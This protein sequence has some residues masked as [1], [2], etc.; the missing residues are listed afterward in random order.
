MTASRHPRAGRLFPAALVL[1]LA[2]VGPLSARA[3]S[4]APDG[5]GPGGGA[6]RMVA[7]ERAGPGE[8]AGAGDAQRL[9]A[10]VVRAERSLEERFA[11]TGSRVTVTRGDIEQMGA[12]TIAD[13]LQKLP[14]VQAAPNAS[15]SVDIRMRGMDRGATQIL[16]DG[17]RVSGGRAGA[18][19]PFDQ[20]PAD[21]IERIEVLRAPSAEY[22]G[23]TGGTLNIVLRESAPRPETSLRLSG[24]QAF[25]EQAPRLFY[26]RNAGLPGDSRW[27]YLVSVSA[28]ERLWGSDLHREVIGADGTRTGGDDHL[29]GRT[30]E[31]TVLPRLNGR[32]S[33]TDSVVLR[34]TLLAAETDSRS[35]G[36]L[37]GARADG[38]PVAGGSR[39]T[40]DIHRQ[41]MQLRADWTRRLS[42]ARLETRASVERSGERIGRERLEWLDTQTASGATNRSTLASDF[43]DRRAEHAAQ[44]AIKLTGTGSEQV[45]MAGLEYEQRRL[46]IDSH[47]ATGAATPTDRQLSSWFSR[48]V[49]WG[50]NEWAVP[51]RG[52]LT[53]G[54][55]A[56]ALSRGTEVDGTRQ[57]DAPEQW[58]PSLHWR[59][60]LAQGWQARANLARIRKLPALTD[61]IDRVIPGWGSNSPARPDLIGNPALRPET[62]LSLDTGLER[63][64][65]GGGQAG[66]NVFVRSIDDL[67]VRRTTEVAG[68][69]QQRPENLGSAL[70]WGI[71]ADVRQHLGAIGARGWNLS[72]NAS[73]LQSRV[74]DGAGWQG[75]I[76]GQAHYLAN[77]SVARPMPRSGGA[78]GGV[79]LSLKGASDLGTSAA[80]G[81][82]ERAR[83]GVDAHAGQLISGLGFWR[84]DVF[85]L[86]NT[87]IRRE[88]VDAVAAGSR[89]EQSAETWGTRLLI[90]VGT[91]W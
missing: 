20:L 28:G 87:R 2:L 91:R 31:L 13:V 30:R 34:A 66:V 77:L 22:S 46:S 48:R 25:G 43:G 35:E 79:S 6:E 4:G 78:F 62:T 18:Q 55:R 53:A 11:S 12:D 89:Y 76:P 7:G 72:A 57:Q 38:S 68:R 49:L 42:S 69:W 52:T 51:G 21:M 15:G 60:P 47:L 61:T 24:Q 27:T 33:A 58:Q 84:L 39:E 85:N 82:R 73:L 41:L 23:A 88:R 50:Q 75:R 45:W 5:A 17:Q 90:T 70:V 71:E 26:S 86:G 83:L 19:L 59:Q 67:I 37:A 32:L 9:D 54:L 80:M 14:G 3:Q 74:D 29:R 63:R 65:E 56:E 10:V 64:L 8:R 40:G 44:A 1:A 36:S 16:V 81:G